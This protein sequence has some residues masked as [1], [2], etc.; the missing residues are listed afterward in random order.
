MINWSLRSAGLMLIFAAVAGVW[1]LCGPAPAGTISSQSGKMVT[2]MDALIREL[3]L[4]IWSPSDQS[5]Q[6]ARNKLREKNFKGLLLIGPEAIPMD[7]GTS[8]P[9]L[10]FHSYTTSNS[11]V[12]DFS[13]TAVI[14]AVRLE[15]CETF[16]GLMV[17]PR[18][19]EPNSVPVVPP[20]AAAVVSQFSCD[21]KTRLK[22]IPWKAGTYLTTALLLDKASN[23]IHTSITPG[24]VAESDPVVA[25]F[26]NRAQ[27]TD[28]P[29]DH[30]YPPLPT[31]DQKKGATASYPIYRR[32]KG[33]PD[34]PKTPP[35]IDLSIDRVV[36]FRPGGRC[37]LRGS[38][39]LPI[40]PR[41]L[42]VAGEK[43]NEVGD[44]QALAVVPID[45]VLVG[46]LN[47]GPYMLKL[48]VPAYEAVGKSKAAPGQVSGS[49]SI[50]LF[51][52]KEMPRMPQTYYIWAFSGETLGGPA[53]MS[54]V[55]EQMLKN[56]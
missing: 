15:S 41:H 46:N 54:I 1:Q 2:T 13:R 39:S 3:N 34:V 4:D 19:D 56:Q 12:P 25:E 48:R 37:I 38:Y 21:V 43:R 26:L 45:L 31:G 8:F 51:S 33:T 47:A 32:E 55:T 30:V 24:K 28:L 18:G 16:A 42:V 23:R 52:L 10:G 20:K 5:I 50:D 35:G 53:P 14:T 44:P 22:E 6:A 27:G 36:V 11:P 17:S 40:L 49:F 9:V 7:A 29:P